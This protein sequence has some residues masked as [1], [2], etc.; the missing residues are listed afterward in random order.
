MAIGS[1]MILWNFRASWSF[2][3]DNS[4]RKRSVSLHRNCEEHSGPQME[5]T[6]WFVHRKK[7]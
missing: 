1:K 2:R 3:Q 6:L 5:L 4:G 7:W